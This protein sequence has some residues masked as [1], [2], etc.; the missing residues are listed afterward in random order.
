MYKI[1]YLINI[2][3]KIK[4]RSLNYFKI[5]KKILD[6]TKKVRNI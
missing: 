5:Y 4:Q 1:Y 6:S 2:Y 3:F